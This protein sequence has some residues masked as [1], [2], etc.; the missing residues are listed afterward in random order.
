M[1]Q[2][3]IRNYFERYGRMLI[4]PAFCAWAALGQASG[5]YAPWGHAIDMASR[6]STLAGAYGATAGGTNTADSPAYRQFANG[7][8]LFRYP[9]GLSVTRSVPTQVTLAS[10]TKGLPMV[11]VTDEG[12]IPDI[13]CLEVHRRILAGYFADNFSTVWLPDVLDETSVRPTGTAIRSHFQ[14]L[15]HPGMVMLATTVCSGNRSISIDS[16]GT[17]AEAKGLAKIV[18]ESLQFRSGENRR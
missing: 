13:G 11:F 15:G 8:F 2:R 1:N 3:G 17:E 14:A 12:E 4:I 10:P 18:I 16:V 9:S 5:Q 6:A 7:R